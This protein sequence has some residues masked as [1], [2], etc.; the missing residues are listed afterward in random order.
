MSGVEPPLTCG[1]WPFHVL[2]VSR[3][4][5]RREAILRAGRR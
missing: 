1:S 5:K 4:R 3:V 2:M